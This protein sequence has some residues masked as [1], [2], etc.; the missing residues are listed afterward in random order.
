ME[1]YFLGEYSF[2]IGGPL[3][4]GAR[5]ARPPRIFW[6]NSRGSQRGPGWSKI[7]AMSLFCHADGKK[8]T[9]SYIE[10]KLLVFVM[11]KAVSN[12][13]IFLIYA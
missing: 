2:S 12:R 13:I 1:E 4:G 5:N 7:R 3:F 11:N 10:T 8:N 6:L 9:F